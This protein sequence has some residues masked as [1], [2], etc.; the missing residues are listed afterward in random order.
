[1]NHISEYDWIKT[2]CGIADISH[3]GQ[4]LIFDRG[5]EKFITELTSS[6]VKNLNEGDIDYLSITNTE[7]DIIVGKIMKD[8]YFILITSGDIKDTI[9]NI[10]NNLPDNVDMKEMKQDSLIS[11]SGNNSDN[12]INDILGINL[13]EMEYMTI[14]EAQLDDDVTSAYIS[15]L[16]NAD[17]YLYKI[18]VPDFVAEDLWDSLISHEDVKEISITTSE[19]IYSDIK[20]N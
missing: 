13:E 9:N 15:K 6:K 1:M 2:K 18:S 19:K 10:R 16:G 12:V 11:I 17:N 4:V 8:C 20:K 3:I 7:S 5:A 14:I